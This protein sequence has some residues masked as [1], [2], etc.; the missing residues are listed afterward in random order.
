M[1][2]PEHACDEQRAAR[3]FALSSCGGA[4]VILPEPP[5]AALRFSF[6]LGV[7]CA[8]T[9]RLYAAGL[10]RRPWWQA[11]A[12]DAATGVQLLLDEYE[13]VDWEATVSGGAAA[14]V[15]NNLCIRKGLCRKAQF[16]E[17]MGTW[18]ARRAPR[19][20]LARAL[21]QTLVL[22]LM[23]VFHNRPPRTELASALAWALSDADEAMSAAAAAA[24]AASAPPPLWIAKPSLT[25]KGAGIAL[26]R[27]AAELE[28]HVLALRDVGMWV[29]QRYCARPL[30]L[31]ARKFHLRVYVLADADLRVHVFREA[32]CLSAARAY[33]ADPAHDGDALV[34]LTNTCVGAASDGFCEDDAVL[35]LSELPVALAEAAAAA[36]PGADAL[37]AAAA[38]T[39]AVYARI[40]AVVAECFLALRREPAAYMP[41]AH[42]FELYGADFMLE[43][44]EAGEADSEGGDDALRGLRLRVL[45]FNPTPDVKQ[46]G[47]RLEPVIAAMLEG[48]LRTCVDSRF[49]P[50]PAR[51]GSPAAAAAVSPA[52]ATTPRAEADM[53][54]EYAA[55]WAAEQARAAAGGALEGGAYGG[56]LQWDC[57]LALPPRP[58]GRSGMSV[59]SFA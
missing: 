56:L 6:H 43:H 49:P 19:G 33:S 45:E 44:A 36:A 15:T 54:E 24:T 55:A 47:V 50:P 34:H 52:A 11:A 46:S 58:G 48:V 28:A 40:C 31:R 10:A 2:H 8:Y 37:A 29:L 51:G 39:A 53:R 9:H 22:D 3:A 57:V 17:H 38:Q 12:P 41:L 20:A 32:L 25:N 30:L 27:S 5:S 16:A 59:S 14:A 42:A 21:P 1:R 18:A 7:D 26:V 35:R 13:R 23:S 4:A